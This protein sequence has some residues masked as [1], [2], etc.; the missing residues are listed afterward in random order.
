M[1]Q[2]SDLNF[3]LKMMDAVHPMDYSEKWP[4]GDNS[5]SME[6]ALKWNQNHFQW[7]QSEEPWM[8]EERKD[9][10]KAYGKK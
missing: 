10:R 1:C 9:V 3:I 7:Q 8:G 4:L 5:N 2:D 6:D